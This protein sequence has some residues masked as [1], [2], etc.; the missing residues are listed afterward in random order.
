M[1]VRDVLH[2][3]ANDLAGFVVQN[4][5]VP[6]RIV[7]AQLI[8]HAVVLAEPQS[9][10]LICS[11]GRMLLNK[12]EVAPEPQMALLRTNSMHRCERMR[13]SLGGISIGK[14]GAE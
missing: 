14:Q 1:S 4:V 3:S 8:R 11:L 10:R 7:P 6:V 9:V 2:D 12:A 13:G 5:T